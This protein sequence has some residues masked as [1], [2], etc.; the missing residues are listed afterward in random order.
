MRSPGLALFS[1]FGTQWID[2]ADVKDFAVLLTVVV[3]AFAYVLGII[4][5]RL[6]DTVL[7]RFEQTRRGKRIKGRMS[8]NRKLSKPAKVA[9]MRMTVMH[10][11]EGM[12]RFLDYQRSRWRI[13]RA[14]VVNLAIAGPVAALYL[15]VGTDEGWLWAL[16]P[17][18]CALVLIPVTYFAGVRIQDA[19]VGR[20]ADAYSIVTARPQK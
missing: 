8:K 19:W 17:P 9:T 3:L 10:E 14:T 13:A 6:A 1:A 16:V 2:L 12:G 20:L 4:V 11:S 7:D 18:A 5:D 15:A